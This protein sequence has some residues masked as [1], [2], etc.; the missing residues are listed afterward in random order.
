[1]NDINSQKEEIL[2]EVCQQVQ[3][4]SFFLFSPL[5]EYLPNLGKKLGEGVAPAEAL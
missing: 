1:M 3:P 5:W 4:V 2:P